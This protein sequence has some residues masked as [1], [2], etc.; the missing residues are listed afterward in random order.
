MVL[1][2]GPL[3]GITIYLYCLRVCLDVCEALKCLAHDTGSV[4]GS[5]LG[6]SPAALT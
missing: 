4:S 2:G 1:F 5:L 6:L 3:G